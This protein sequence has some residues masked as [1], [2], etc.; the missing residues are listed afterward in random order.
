MDPQTLRQDCRDAMR[1]IQAYERTLSAALLERLKALGAQV[2]GIAD[3]GRLHERVPTVCFNLP[4]RAPAQVVAAAAEAA[5][6]RLADYDHVQA[7]R[8]QLSE[9][10]TT[11]DRC[12]RSI[13]DSSCAQLC[14]TVL[15][16]S[17]P[18]ITLSK[19]F[20]LSCR[21]Y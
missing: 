6:A 2:Y 10:K 4:G 21:R 7:L 1:G 12:F 17:F 19:S 8:A 5:C 13:S 14:S 11:T 16:M 18:A 9:L 20:C 3:T 15:V